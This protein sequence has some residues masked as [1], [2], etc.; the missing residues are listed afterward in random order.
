MRFCHPPG[1]LAGAPEGGEKQDEG[2]RDGAPAESRPC[3][4]P[5]ER[6]RGDGHNH[7]RP[8]CQSSM[9]A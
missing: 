7:R 9:R 2:E 1:A 5:G 3:A 6:P 8:F 4:R